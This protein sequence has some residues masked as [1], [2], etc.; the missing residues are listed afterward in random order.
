MSKN[1]EEQKIIYY[2][3]ELN[4]EFAGDSIEPIPIDENYK[5]GSKSFFWNLTHYFW[6]RIFALPIAALFLKLKYHHKIINRE[7]IKPYT[8]SAFFMYG[9]HTNNICDALIPT[10][11]QNWNHT[12]VIVNPNNVSMPVLGKITPYLGAI[13]LPGNMAATKNFMNII[14]LRMEQKCSITIYPEAHIWPFYT[15]IRPFVDLS[16]RYPVQYN[17]P[18]FCFTNTYQKYKNSKT[19]QIVTYVDGPF[20]AD[21]NLSSKEKKTDLRNKVY[22]AMVERSKNNNVELIKY[23]KKESDKPEENND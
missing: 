16:F 12:Y 20:F 3:D 7:V 1:K 6:Y 22:A 2:T 5:Y 21:E 15:K 13:P 4:D 19:P 8:K 9:N 17:V 23:I 11:V 18:T 14:K 10:F